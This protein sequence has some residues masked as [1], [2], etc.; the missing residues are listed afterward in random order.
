M[1]VELGH[2]HFLYVPAVL[3]IVTNGIGMGTKKFLK[4]TVRLGL[5]LVSSLLS[6]A[7][8]L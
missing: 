4:G 3:N 6:M 8:L 1:W 5:S 2:S 7:Q